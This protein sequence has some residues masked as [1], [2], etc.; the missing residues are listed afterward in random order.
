MTCSCLLVIPCTVGNQVEMEHITV[1]HFLIRSGAVSLC[2]AGSVP[3]T[4][5]KPTSSRDVHNAP[6]AT[7]PVP[8]PTC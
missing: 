5:K 8:T 1:I 3:R 6:T 4:C 2:D 7:Q